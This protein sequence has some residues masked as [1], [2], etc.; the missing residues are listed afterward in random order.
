MTKRPRPTIVD[1]YG[2]PPDAVLTAA[3]VRAWWPL[4]GVREQIARR[5]CERL[6]L[7]ADEDVKR[8][9]SLTPEQAVRFALEEFD[10]LDADVE[11]WLER[12]RA[13][14]VR[15]TV[16]HVE[17][18]GN[19]DDQADQQE[20]RAGD[21]VM[22]HVGEVLAFGAVE[23]GDGSAAA[24]EAVV[25]YI[26][27]TVLRRG[28]KG[29]TIHPFRALKAADDA[30]W[31]PVYEAAQRLDVPVWVYAEAHPWVDAPADLSHPRHIDRVACEF[32]GLKLII[33]HGGRPWA[34]DA[35]ETALRHP[36]VWLDLSGVRAHRLV[37]P[38][39]G[40][41]PFAYH[42]VRGLRKRILWGGRGAFDPYEPEAMIA[43]YRNAGFA[44]E[45][46]ADWLGGNA[47]DLLRLPEV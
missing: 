46:V 8:L 18:G 28:F 34:A 12:R 23:P 25:R 3:A 2:R 27:R 45:I 17:P 20:R 24:A 37:T 11:L 33:G 21:L 36:T 26:E 4:R 22:T 19:P 38:G 42:G 39:A 7:V 15:A 43:E 31:F 9:V 40:F 35:A 1:L 13:A 30:A 6:G 41:E 29:V 14:G 5:L 16:L 10:T 44:P 47:A 32:P